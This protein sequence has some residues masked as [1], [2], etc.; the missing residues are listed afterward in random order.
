MLS[1]AIREIFLWISA[2]A[3]D[4]VV[5]NPNGIKTLS[6]NGLRTYLI[7]PIQDGVFWGCSRME[8][9]V[10]APSLKSVTHILK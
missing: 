10:K 5:V 1:C 6:P 2:S 4:A 3:T 7:N 9:G 8:G